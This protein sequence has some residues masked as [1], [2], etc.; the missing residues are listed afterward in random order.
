VSETDFAKQIFRI[1][2]DT[3]YAKRRIMQNR[4]DRSK[5]L[6]Y[7]LTYL[8]VKCSSLQKPLEEAKMNMFSAIDSNSCSKGD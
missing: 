2:V 1:F 7:L 6:T 5:R 8:R 3:D 4:C